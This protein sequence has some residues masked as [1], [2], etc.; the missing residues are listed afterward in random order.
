MSKGG[1]LSYQ[2]NRRFSDM[3]SFGES[4]HAFKRSG[5]AAAGIFSYNTAKTY[6]REC[7][8]FAKWVK[9]RHPEQIKS[10]DDCRPYIREY[11]THARRQDGKAF[12]A[13]S[14]ATKAAAIAKLYGEQKR[15]TEKR[16]RGAITR[17][18]KYQPGAFERAN[19]ELVSFCDSTGLR[20]HELET[21]RGNQ[22]LFRDGMYQ[23]SIKGNQAKGGKPRLVPIIGNIALVVRIMKQAGN[24]KVFGTVSKAFDIHAHRAIYAGR[25][26]QQHAR[27]LEQC[28]REPFFDQTRGVM[29]RNS[30]YYCRG[31]QAGRVYDKAAMLLVSRALGHNRISVI[32]E[33]YLYNLDSNAL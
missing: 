29:R 3:F 31:D 10:L 33:H 21:L 17:S 27:S 15:K 25:L 24:E 23:I 16:R 26:Y 5:E 7:C 28:K 30:V 14:L 22:L 19:P 2:V 11:L 12:S 4:K 20:R 9:A 32:A 6:I 1:S 13:Y 8:N 18:R